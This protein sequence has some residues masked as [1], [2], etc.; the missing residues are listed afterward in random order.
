MKKTEVFNRI[1]TEKVIAIIR[2][3]DGRLT[4]GVVD[5][6]VEGGINVLEITSNTP[7]F[8]KE[9]SQAR[10]RHTNVLIGAGTITNKRLAKQAIEA[11]AQFLVTP[12]TNEGIIEVASTADVPVIMGAFTPTE[13]ADAL[14]YGADAIKLF[15][16]NQLGIP[17]YKSIKGPFS[18]SLFF[19]VGGIGIHN[20]EEWM[21][22]GV[23]GVGVGSALIDTDIQTDED[24]KN[25][26]VRAEKLLEF[27]R[28][29]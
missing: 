6:L 5:N 29:L 16:S 23:N 19:A 7:D 21:T 25:I 14:S 24:L 20:I 13:I 18:D 22:A 15:P 26:S 4:G 17:Y 27:I 10:E 3:K 1:V 8:T 28:G 9:I 2:L 12:N 11:G